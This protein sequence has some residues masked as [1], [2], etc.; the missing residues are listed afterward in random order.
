MPQQDQSDNIS[1]AR[2]LLATRRF[3]KLDEWLLS[4]MRGWQNQGE[5]QSD[6][7]LLMHPATLFTGTESPAL[8]PLKFSVTGRSNA[9][10]ATTL[11]YC[12]AW[13]GMKMPG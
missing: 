13:S 10:R 12:W 3:L 6:Y 4:L 11:T 5:G 9:R 1:K 2:M 7:G 8:N